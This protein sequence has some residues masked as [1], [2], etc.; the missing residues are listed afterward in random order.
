MPPANGRDTLMV[1]EYLDYA[2]GEPHFDGTA[3]Q[4]VR[5]GIER[6]VDLDMVIGMDL[7]RMI[8]RLR[9]SGSPRRQRAFV[10]GEPAAAL[11]V[12]VQAGIINLFADLSE[13]MKLSQLFISH[14]LAVVR[15]LCD[16]V[17]VIYRGEIVEMAATEAIFSSPKHDYTRQ[18]L[19]AAPDLP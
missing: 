7:R 4:P 12:S 11:D 18:L 19:T 2:M 10:A 16:R 14:N 1:V 8:W 5:H 9:G 17:A 13:E 3:D 15:S 6:L